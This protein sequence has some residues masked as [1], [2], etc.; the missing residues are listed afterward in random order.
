[1][2]EFHVLPEIY[3]AFLHVTTMRARTFHIYSSP[4]HYMVGT[5][6][7]F[8]KERN[9][10]FISLFVHTILKPLLRAIDLKL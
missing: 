7:I 5:Q 4:L 9:K 1:M 2:A 8:V 3:F 6:K 10:V